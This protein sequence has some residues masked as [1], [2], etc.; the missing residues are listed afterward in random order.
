VSAPARERLKEAML[1]LVIEQGYEATSVDQVAAL[2]GVGR[3]EFDRCFASKE[4]C[5]IAV[6]DHFQADFETKVMAAYGS[7][8]NWPDNLRAAAYAIADWSTENPRG[9]RFGTVEMLW[10]SDAAQ[11]RRLNGFETFLGMIEAGR[12]AA[13]DP[14][15]IP[16]HTA[17]R[18]MGSVAEILTRR[19]QGKGFDA[20]AF[21]PELMA[22][23]VTAY[24]GEGT[25]ARELA[26]PPPRRAQGG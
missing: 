10:I 23:I 7:E 9:M 4:E 3:A 13:P 1:E 26:I 15:S 17:G 6:F 16:P 5:A 14:D 22:L 12:E 2:A 21:V 24:L 18:L 8:P 25:G 11:A 20:R 19:M